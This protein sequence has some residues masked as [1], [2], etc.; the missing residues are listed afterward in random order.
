MKTVGDKLENFVVTGVKPGALTP[1]GAFE[2]ITDLSFEGKW[3]VI[4]FYPKD[5]TF[6]CPTE[7]VAYVI[8]TPLTQKTG[9]LHEEVNSRPRPCVNASPR[10]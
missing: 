4:V 7:I 9:D 3:K 10:C 6:V 8:H 1:D 5:F 2:D